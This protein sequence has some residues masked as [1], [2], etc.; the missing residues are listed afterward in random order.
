VTGPWARTTFFAVVAGYLAWQ[1]VAFFRSPSTLRIAAAPSVVVQE[2]AAGQPVGET[3]RSPHDG[4]ES[5]DLEFSSTAPAAVDVTCRLLGWANNRIADGS[6]SWAAVYEWPVTLKLPAGRSVQH[7]AFKTITPS[8]GLVYQFQVQQR[9]VRSLDSKPAGPPA[10]GV[11]ASARDEF[12]DGN[13]IVGTQ[14]IVD[15]DLHLEVHAANPYG[16]FRLATNPKLPPKLR[17]V[18]AQLGLLAFFNVAL[19]AFAYQVV[20]RDQATSTAGRIHG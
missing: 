6:G 13:I 9:R 5:A 18:T 4:L 16:M 12:P 1:Y 15:R 3:F 14:Q 17:T 19:V 10:V 2:F 8:E 11:M 7:F 20:M